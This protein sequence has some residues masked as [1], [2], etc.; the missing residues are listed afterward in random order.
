MYACVA[1]SPLSRAWLQM[2]LC[3]VLWGFTGILGKL[4]TLEAMSLVWWRMVFVAGSLLLWRRFWAGLSSMGARS[5]AI[6]A[7]TG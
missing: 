1:V 5:L 3:V 4:I 7:G 6:C 2:H